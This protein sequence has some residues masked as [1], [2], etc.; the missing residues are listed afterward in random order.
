MHGWAG[1]QHALNA[2]LGEGIDVEQGPAA[3]W[4]F[5]ISISHLSGDVYWR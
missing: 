3:C 4:P 1:I 5:V 2:T